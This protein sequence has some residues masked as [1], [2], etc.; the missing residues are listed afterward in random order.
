[1]DD[2]MLSLIAKRVE[3]CLAH[4]RGDGGDCEFCAE[5]DRCAFRGGRAN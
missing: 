5:S 3:Q 1:M 4:A 2:L